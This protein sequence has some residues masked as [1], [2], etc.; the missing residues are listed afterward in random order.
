MVAHYEARLP[1]LPGAVE[2]VH[3]AASGYPVALAS[4]SPTELIDKV[5]SLTGLDKVF[6]TIVYGDTISRG[7]PAPDIYLEAA[8]R[9]DVSPT[10]CLG[11]EDSANGIRSLKAA[12][13]KAIAVP[14]PEYPLTKEILNLADRVLPT[15]EEFSVD[16]VKTLG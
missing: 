6:K 11:I 5:M 8:R 1:V 4:G 10:T 13:M 12:G 2:A 3:I 7:K 14:S 15:L 16:L 9:L